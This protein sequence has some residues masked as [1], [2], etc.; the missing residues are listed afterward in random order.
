MPIKKLMLFQIAFLSCRP[1]GGLSLKYVF[2]GEFSLTNGL[3][4]AAALT[5]FVI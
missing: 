2:L 5:V 1:Q 3:A 4:V